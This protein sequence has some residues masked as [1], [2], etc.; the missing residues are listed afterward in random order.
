MTDPDRFT[1]TVARCLTH[2]TDARVD[3]VTDIVR[4]VLEEAPKAPGRAALEELNLA[5][6]QGLRANNV[7]EAKVALVYGGATKIKG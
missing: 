7:P 1:H 2:G 5:V 6:T 3:P 4:R